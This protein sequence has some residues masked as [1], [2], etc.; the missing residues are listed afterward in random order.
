VL[1]LQRIMVASS[2]CMGKG[3]IHYIEVVSDSE[4]EEGE[5]EMGVIHNL[6]VNQG[7]EEKGHT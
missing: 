6:E 2:Q 5:E 1:H 4:D 7:E 3:K